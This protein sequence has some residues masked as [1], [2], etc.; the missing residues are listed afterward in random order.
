[1]AR[2][3]LPQAAPEP[4]QGF[5]SVDAAIRKGPLDWTVC[6][7]VKL[8]VSQINGCVVCVD[9]HHGEA[10]RGGESEERL[11]Q[12]VVWRESALFD[13]RE[14]TALAYA[15]AVTDRVP[16]DDELWATMRTHFPTDA[17]LGHL[18]AQVSLINALNLFSV[19]LQAR[20]RSS[21]AD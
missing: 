20:P 7:L 12:L 9:K 6:E 10:R 1:M 13:E 19:P 3:H 16:V 14:R 15:E 4:Y 5:L 17:E 2:L 11:S 18:V 21:S 8:R